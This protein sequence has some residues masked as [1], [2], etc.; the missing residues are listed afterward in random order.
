MSLACGANMSQR[1]KLGDLERYM[2]IYSSY[3]YKKIT[4]IL[5]SF[6]NLDDECIDH[7]SE[8]SCKG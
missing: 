7:T 1:N 5:N 8:V 2:D 4:F 6:K 3:G